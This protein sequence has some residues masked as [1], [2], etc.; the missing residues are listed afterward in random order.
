MPAQLLFVYGTLLEPGNP[1]AAYLSRHCSFL[2]H[3]KIKG[4]LYD[5]GDYPGLILDPT[6]DDVWGSVYLLQRD[7]ILIELDRYEGVGPDEEQPELYVRLLLA[8]A[9]AGG[10]VDA[11]AYVYNR[12]VDNLTQIA[13]GDYLEYLGQKKI[14]R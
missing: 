11:W 12:P 7:N 6:A 9:T 8:V 4:K 3:G 5:V 2:A 10:W 14:P 13:C 1:F